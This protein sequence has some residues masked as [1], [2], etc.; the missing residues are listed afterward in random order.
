MQVV[1]ALIYNNE[2]DLLHVRFLETYDVVDHFIIIE[3]PHTFQGNPKPLHFQEE[4]CGRFAPYLEKVVHVVINLP[5]DPNISAWRREHASR[6]CAPHHKWSMVAVYAFLMNI[7]A[8]E[9]SC[10]MR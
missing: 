7:E 2:A 1:S 3:A 5:A 8:K 10:R 4:V 6:V 9:C